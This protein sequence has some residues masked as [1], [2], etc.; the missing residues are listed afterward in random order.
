MNEPTTTCED[1]GHQRPINAFCGC[2]TG[3]RKAE[4]WHQRMDSLF[5]RPPSTEDQ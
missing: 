5:K 4:Q 3:Q 2:P 1:C